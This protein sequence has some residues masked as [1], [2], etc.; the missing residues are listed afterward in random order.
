V[1][2]AQRGPVKLAEEKV[3]IKKGLKDVYFDRSE[4][5]FI[6]A[7][8][9]TL[10]Y[11][12]YNIHDLAEH[13]TFEETAYLLLHGTLPTSPQLGEFDAQLKAERRLPNEILQVIRITKDAHPMD[14]LRTAVSA[15]SSLDSEVSDN[16]HAST[17]RKGV[18]L[19]SAAATIVAAHARLRDGKDPVSPDTDLTHAAN[20]L[21][22]LFGN[23]PDEKD[24]RLIDKDLVLHAEHGV[25]AS[26]FGARV[27]ASTGA[28]FYAAIT[29]A[30]AVLK[31][32]KHG[33]AAENV[34]NMAK[35]IGSADKAKD[36]VESVVNNGGR[37]PGFGHPV[38]RTIDPRTVHLK[39]D[40]KELGERKGN[41]GWFSILQA[42]TETD[43]MKKRSRLGHHPNV[44]L[45]AGAVYSLLGIPNDLF[46]PLF[47]IGRMPGWTS[48]ILEQYNRKDILRPRLQYSGPMEMPYVPIE[49]RN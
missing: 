8:N 15:M 19:T 11:R 44:D 12:G 6:D 31:G 42:V 14:V 36:Y 35:E 45:W 43:T 34:M 32:P 20:L 25:N 9:G 26:T 39:A 24:T 37:I 49:Q 47:A 41:P 29:A 4:S 5:S 18:R 28:D 33:G 40:A 38:Y 23:R 7:K 13:S 21:Y 30:I 48:H 10:L 2:T 3:E 17:M 46:I 1:E 27:A 22:M 16:S